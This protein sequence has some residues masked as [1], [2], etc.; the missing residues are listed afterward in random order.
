MKK[1]IP[2]T[3]EIPFQDGI[4]EIL[5]ISLDHDLSIKNQVLMGNF[6]LRGKYLT[7]EEKEEE[8]S[9]K[10][11]FEIS[12]NDK[13][14]IDD[15]EFDIEDFYYDVI[16]SE[17]LKVNIE[18]YIDGLIEKEE[19]TEEKVAIKLEDDWERNEDE[20]TK[21]EN[22]VK[23]EDVL[24]NINSNN[25]EKYETYNIYIF[26]DNDTLSEIME[27][28]HTNKEL[29][30]EYNDLESIQTGSKIIIPSRKDE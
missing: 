24:T 9:Y 10:I 2:F 7:K 16:D 15:T 4:S 3:K 30:Q 12:I 5:S 19:P 14:D 29:L 21:E 11:P 1:I 25:D 26:R 18:V 13:Y 6:Y 22:I 17:K 27:K 20:T 23:V 28:Y 8:Y